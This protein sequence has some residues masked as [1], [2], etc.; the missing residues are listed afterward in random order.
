MRGNGFVAPITV[1]TALNSSAVY[2]VELEEFRYNDELTP[3][4][5]PA[6]I[7]FDV[8]FTLAP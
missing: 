7:C 6:R 2:A 8:S 5:Y 4:S 1:T 3:A